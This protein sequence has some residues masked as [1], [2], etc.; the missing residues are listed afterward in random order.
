MLHSERLLTRL[1]LSL[2]HFD[3]MDTTPFAARSPRLSLA[4]IFNP[5][6]TP[7][8]PLMSPIISARDGIPMGDPEEMWLSDNMSSSR[9]MQGL[10]DDGR[11]GWQYRE[12]VLCLF[13][14]V[15]L[16]KFNHY[17]THSPIFRL[18]PLDDISELDST[19]TR[20]MYRFAAP[21]ELSPLET[22]KVLDLTLCEIIKIENE[23]RTLPQNAFPTPPDT[24]VQIVSDLFVT[25]SENDR[26]SRRVS[27]VPPVYVDSPS[28]DGED[29]EYIGEGP[30]SRSTSHRKSSTDKYHA[31]KPRAPTPLSTYSPAPP[32]MPLRS[33]KPRNDQFE[34]KTDKP[35][36][37]IRVMRNIKGKGAIPHWECPYC[38]DHHAVPRQSDMSRHI[39]THFKTKDLV[40]VACSLSF[41]RPDA[42]KRHLNKNCGR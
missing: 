38:A 9:D 1:S 37:A 6:C 20:S 34:L 3:K 35:L 8:S 12:C 24:P 16:Y 32:G 13:P 22:P 27:R 18:E 21:S 10:F 2:T 42:L 28:D 33:T 17:H 36:K 29:D 39:K 11:S 14:F 31:R 26:H 23:E 40:C 25:P 15:S 41:S 7:T 5:L 30:S 4:S 19:F